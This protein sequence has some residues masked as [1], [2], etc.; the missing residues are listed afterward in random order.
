MTSRLRLLL[1][2]GFFLAA[3]AQVHPAGLATATFVEALD[4]FL[5]RT[6]DVG[7]AALQVAN[8]GVVPLRNHVAMPVARIHTGRRFSL[9]DRLQGKG[10]SVQRRRLAEGDGSG[11]TSGYAVSRPAATS[12]GIG[13][14]L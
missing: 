14:V 8:D 12:G 10:I 6:F 13:P 11:H 9:G 4:D 2:S 7:M 1:R 5:Y 3:R